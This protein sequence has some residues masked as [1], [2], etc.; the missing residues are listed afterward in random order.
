LR[1]G[2]FGF[3]TCREDGHA[4]QIEGGRGWDSQF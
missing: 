3:D 4:G 1:G 2:A